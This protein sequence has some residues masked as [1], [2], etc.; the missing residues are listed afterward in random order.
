MKNITSSSTCGSGLL[1][2][3]NNLSNSA[4]NT[5]TIVGGSVIDDEDAILH[6][7]KQKG[8]LFSLRT[9]YSTVATYLLASCLNC[10]MQRLECVYVWVWSKWIVLIDCLTDGLF[11]DSTACCNKTPTRARRH[12]ATNVRPSGRPLSTIFPSLHFVLHSVV[13][14]FLP[15]LLSLLA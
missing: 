13:C 4:T 9:P 6:E 7:S 15:C 5:S 12:S 10:C 14:N 11:I 3:Q 1:Q 2:L 8:L